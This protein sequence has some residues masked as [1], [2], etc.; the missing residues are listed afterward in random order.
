MA[1][2]R[3][4]I[5][6]GISVVPIVS[7]RCYVLRG[8]CQTL[9]AVIQK[10]S[11]QK[12]AVVETRKCIT[13]KYEIS[14]VPIVSSCH[15]LQGSCQTLGAVIQKGSIQKQVVAET[16]KCITLKYE[17]SVVPIVSS[18]HALQGSCQTLGAVTEKGRS[19]N[20]VVVETRKQI[21]GL[22]PAKLHSCYV[23]VFLFVCCLFCLDCGRQKGND[24]DRTPLLAASKCGG[25][26]NS[27]VIATHGN[28][29]QKEK[30]PHAV[31]ASSLKVP[32]SPAND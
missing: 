31:S 15:A 23:F 11:I 14:V 20:Q 17:I 4:C 13:L 32:E 1:E 28:F 18:C 7:S 25:K 8:S 10:G 30:R 12:Q 16:R 29:K 24:G 27:R 19:Q 21:H 2:T 6:Y 22:N 9:G 26:E 3:K 5:K